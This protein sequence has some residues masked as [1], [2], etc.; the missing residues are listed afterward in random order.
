MPSA[1]E[2][3]IELRSLSLGIVCPMANVEESAVRFVAMVLSATEEFG[4]VRFYAVLD[5]VSHDKTRETLDDLAT[6]E[7]RLQVVWAPENQCVVDAYM[8][9]YKEAIAGRHDYILEIDAG[10]SHRP[11]D[12]PVF[13]DAIID[14]YECVFGSRFMPGGKMADTA[15]SR[16]MISRGGSMLANLVLDTRFHDMTSGFELFSR[17]ALIKIL[18][19]GIH[20]RAHFF[21]TEIKYH[22]RNMRIIE[23]PIY[24]SSA[25]PSVGLRALY[26]AFRQLF[27]L[28]WSRWRGV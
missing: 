2:H 3:K 1:G 25:S 24:Y 20:S 4:R 19:S 9:G 14:G 11:E 23:V 22:A 5:R 28:A 10:F 6:I 8:R 18:D 16:R 17:P 26:D 7:N 13:F 27:R 15:L 12:L 21:Q